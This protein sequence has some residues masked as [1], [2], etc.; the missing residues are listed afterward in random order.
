VFWGTLL[1]TRRWAASTGEDG[2]DGRGEDA[3]ASADAGGGGGAGGG[4]GPPLIFDTNGSRDDCWSRGGYG[5]LG[6][7]RFLNANGVV[8]AGLRPPGLFESIDMRGD[9]R[10]NAAADMVRVPGGSGDE[11]RD[12][13]DLFV[14]LMPTAGDRLLSV[15]GR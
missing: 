12:E 3:G 7:V 9:G 14:G 2:T 5:E 15:G 11:V 4:A 10:L 13:E 8:S 1:G 6:N